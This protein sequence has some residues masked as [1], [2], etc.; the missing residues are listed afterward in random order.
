MFVAQFWSNSD[1]F[2]HLHI[3]DP[4]LSL[5]ASQTAMG[6]TPL[7][8]GKETGVSISDEGKPLSY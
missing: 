7:H 6:W 8:K 2:V 3:R 4:T 1:S 5:N